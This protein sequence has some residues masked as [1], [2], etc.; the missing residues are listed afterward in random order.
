MTL[1]ACADPDEPLFRTVL[2]RYF[3]AQDDPQTLR[4][5]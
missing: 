5:V 4:L 3:D 2:D 1:F